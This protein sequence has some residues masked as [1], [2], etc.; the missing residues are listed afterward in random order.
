MK[1]I[2][3]CIAGLGNVG[4]A[5]IQSIE[6]NN[7][8]FKKK[9]SLEI[10]IV[11]ISANKKNKKRNF[12]IK[13]YRW[14]E[15]P[16]DMALLDGCN[17]IVE[18][19][20]QEKGISYDLIKL[21]LNNN[22]HVVTGNKA[23]IS[24]HGKDLFLLAEKNKLSLSFEAAVAGGI[25]IIK[26]IKDDISLNKI[27]KISGILNGTTN[28]ILSKMD[29]ENLSFDE[30]LNIAKQKGFTSDHESKLDIGGYDAAHKLTILSTLCYGASLDFNNNYIQGISDIKI[31]DINFAKKL[32]YN[33]KLI[34]ESFI[35][36]NKI[37]NFTSPKLINKNN[38]L[39]NVGD[40]LNALN[41]ETDHLDN[42]FVEGQGAGGKPTA[43]S[44]LSDIYYIS[45][46]SNFN[47]LG[48]N[49]ENLIKFEKYPIKKIINRYYL[50][51]MTEDKPG[52]LS[53]ITNLFSKTGIS[54]EKILQLPEIAKSNSP[55]PILITTHQIQREILISVINT[56]EDNEF[57]Q[58][59]IT[60]LP[61]HD[62]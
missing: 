60:I 30:V 31:E 45:Q 46:N 23:L 19:I 9:H 22:K 35:H 44:V 28:Y 26:L 16:L 53:T 47:N 50:R 7:I 13:K 59:R 48:F 62:D 6:E 34:S 20:G 37:Y 42:L 38:P 29:E 54:V 25:P 24:Q 11:G 55:I 5:L 21:S 32:G 41:I 27:T 51:I 57:V 52:V 14:F 61:I 2:N 36:N 58:E 49:V 1:K 43:S 56:L 18:L 10:N 4:T 40:A 8:L 15:N 33:I 39:A 12:N 3:I 17:I